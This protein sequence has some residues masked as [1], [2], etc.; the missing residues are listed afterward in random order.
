MSTLLWA[1][2]SPIAQS[3][4]AVD[5][6]QWKRISLEKDRPQKGKGSRELLNLECSL[7]YCS[8]VSSKH[9]KRKAHVC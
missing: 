7:I 5:K 9:G 8:G 1:Q 3:S 4:S 6:G 2:I